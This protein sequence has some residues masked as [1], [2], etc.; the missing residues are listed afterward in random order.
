MDVQGVQHQSSL[1]LTCPLQLRGCFHPVRPST[2]TNPLYAMVGEAPGKQEDEKGAPFIGRSGQVLRD[3]MRKAGLP[4]NRTL[5]T[6]I[7]WCAP[8]PAPGEKI[9][10][11]TP[12]ECSKC[13]P[14]TLLLFAAYK[15]Q[16]IV[17]V[18]A[19]SFVGLCGP[20]KPT[21]GIS[22]NRG[23]WR[24]LAVSLS[25]RYQTMRLWLRGKQA[26]GRIS[27]LEL[28]GTD[29]RSLFGAVYEPETAPESCEK[30]IAHAVEYL[31]YS[32]GWLATP[33]MPIVHPASLLYSGMGPQSQMA[34][35]MVGD[36]RKVKD[37]SEGVL[38]ATTVRNYRWIIDLDEFAKYVDETIAMYKAG[39]VKGVS[40]DLETSRS[41]DPSVFLSCFNP[42]VR[43]LTIQFSRSD[44]EAVCLMVHHKDSPFHNELSTQILRHHLARFLAE[45]PTVYQNALFDLNMLRCKLGIENVRIVGDTLLMAHW[46]TCG[47]QQLYGLDELGERYLG[48]GRHKTPAHKW[49]EENPG[50]DFDEMPLEIALDY[51]CGDADVTRRVYGVLRQKLTEENRWK[52]FWDHYFGVHDGWRVIFDLTWHGMP[53]DPEKL[54]VLVEKYPAKIEAILLDINEHQDVVDYLKMRYDM[55][56][57]S[58]Q[59]HNLQCAANPR[60]RKKTVLPFDQWRRE[61][62][63]RFSPSSVPATVA[64]WTNMQMP[65]RLFHRPEF[66][67]LEWGD[68]DCPT[69]GRKCRCEPKW[70]PKKFKT[71]EHN[72]DVIAKAMEKY[73][74]EYRVRGEIQKADKCQRYAGL[75]GLLSKFKSL[76]KLNGTYV[77]GISKFIV[78]KPEGPP[79][80]WDTSSRVFPLYRPYCKYPR[81][82]SLHPSYNM[83]GTAT[84]RLS[85]SGPNAQNFP[86]HS[87]SE[88]GNVKAPYI[89]R[90]AGKGG[91]LIQPDYSQIEVRVVVAMCQDEDLTKALNSGKDIHR[92][93]ASLVHGI[94]EDKVTDDLRKPVK[95]VTFGILYGQSVESLAQE[96]KIPTE[97][98]QRIQDLFFSKFPKVKN[99]VDA[100]HA[101]GRTLGYVTTPLGRRRYLGSLESVLNN[102]STYQSKCIQ[103]GILP[104]SI[105]VWWKE[106]QWSGGYSGEERAHISGALREAVNTPIQSVASDLCWQAYGRTWKQLRE[107]GIECCPHS[108]I[109]DSQCFDLSPGVL[110]DVVELQYNQMVWETQRLYPWMIVKPEADFAVGASWGTLVG[111]KLFW[112]DDEPEHDRIGLA[113]KKDEVEA[114]VDELRNAGLNP[115]VDGKDGEHPKPEEAAKGKWYKEVRFD[116]P[117]PRC[118]LTKDKVLTI[119][120]RR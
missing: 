61:P 31:G 108:I 79:D 92:Y 54:K 41:D 1:C 6:N 51:A 83:H 69:C 119:H 10:T 89:S 110:M 52:Q 66:R 33:V 94:P 72:R 55:D 63:N 81:P 42:S 20:R 29:L 12:E 112:H 39:T 43:I 17:A 58:V 84:G 113:G 116:R 15:P 19:S 120:A 104:H 109:H 5:F 16:V 85:S 32:E 37:R 118:L 21:D 48:T 3:A 13:R 90:W 14:H 117:N 18:G 97:E 82:W 44:N 103:G 36:L 96:L 106:A 60:K 77:G 73:A 101:E 26:Q 40:V 67:D 11:P 111:L 22:K 62:K 45:V 47:A 57:L 59:E 68:E 99:F 115:R 88:A 102:Y 76:D 78:D 25:D 71:S 4:E 64:L 9:G 114:V 80:Q 100:K 93:V 27:T 95:R 75:M 49:Q 70:K 53:I 56:C 65:D 30:Q 86:G 105:D 28:P 7:C 23:Q 107:V 34:E 24:S 8:R 91:L 38:P 87:D 74:G 50:K 46:L 2:G 35:D 98:A